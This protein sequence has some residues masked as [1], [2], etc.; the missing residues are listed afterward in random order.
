MLDEGTFA[1]ILMVVD[2]TSCYKLVTQLHA[3]ILKYG[4]VMDCVL[5]NA[6]ITAYLLCGSIDDSRKVFEKMG[7]I[8]DLVILNSLLAAYATLM[9][10]H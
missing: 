1:C 9:H 10:S 6:M 3:K 7:G 4:R 5:Y 8:R 2:E